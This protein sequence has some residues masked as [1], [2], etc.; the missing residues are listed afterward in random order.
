MV[1][2]KLGGWL[3]GLWA[4]SLFHSPANA[5]IVTLWDEGS[6]G[7]LSSTIGVPTV[8]STPLVPNEYRVSGSTINSPI[9]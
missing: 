8:F 1:A 2:R 9:D 3:F 6:Q 7:D 5:A 4:V